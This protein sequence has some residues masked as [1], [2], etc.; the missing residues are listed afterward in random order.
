MNQDMDPCT[1]FY[2]F[3]CGGYER[4]TMLPTGYPKWNYAMQ[5]SDSIYLT[6]K[7]LLENPHTKYEGMA[8][9]QAKIYYDSCLDKTNV[10]KK[11]QGMPLKKLLDLYGGW[12][13][14]NVY[15]KSSAFINASS[16][17]K[18]SNPFLLKKIV[19]YPEKGF[20]D[21]FNSVFFSLDIHLDPKNSSKNLLFIFPGELTF[22]HKDY[23]DDND[24]YN[25]SLMYMAKIGNLLLK[26]RTV[27]KYL[28]MLDENIKFNQHAINKSDL[29][30]TQ[31]EKKKQ[32]WSQLRNVMSNILDLEKLIANI[33]PLNMEDTKY[34]SLQE[35]DKN[36]DF[37]NWTSFINQIFKPL[38]ISIA[39]DHPFWVTSISYMEALTSLIK[40]YLNEPNSSRILHDYIMWHKIRPLTR[41]LSKKFSYDPNVKDNTSSDWKLCLEEFP[42]FM[43]F[44]LSSLYL[45]SNFY[46]RDKLKL[47]EM[48]DMIKLSYKK[49]LQD[50]NW[51]DK[52]TKARSIAK[53]DA[54]KFKIGYPDYIINPN[55]LDKDY[56]GRNLFFKYFLPPH[57]AE[58]YYSWSENDITFLAG[59]LQKP[60]YDITYPNTYLFGA[61]GSLISHE[62]SHGFDNNGRNYDE[63]GNL[64]KWWTNESI[65]IYQEKIN[66][67]QKQYSNYS[68]NSHKLNFEQTLGEDIADNGGVFIS[69]QALKSYQAMNKS[70]IYSSKSNITDE[71]LFFLAYAQVFGRTCPDHL[72][73]PSRRTQ[74]SDETELDRIANTM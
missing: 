25:S 48:V 57:L 12:D 60:Y 66:C 14:L 64:N 17:L 54:M 51:M 1:D 29:N 69:L 26:N 40:Q 50:L 61:I 11:L 4:K 74:Y 2:E 27:S 56:L 52:T 18:K 10:R 9:R 24:L 34:Q 20:P 16:T 65:K 5:I 8:E 15:K 70:A 36:F 28:E 19:R 62:I 44:P 46:S 39:A 45:K 73:G 38:N 71:Q 59:L 72:I 23:Y 47:K 58:A 42:M 53:V 35:L 32:M 63:K 55:E 30:R 31:K 3:A 6:I 41:Y 67:Y 33:T 21:K 37:M 68:I 22:P 49:S 7:D 13:L 43:N